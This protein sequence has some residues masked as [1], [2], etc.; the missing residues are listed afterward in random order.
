MGNTANYIV[1]YLSTMMSEI[2]W[3]PF[4]KALDILNFD[5][6]KIILIIG[7]SN[8]T[9]FHC[10][11]LL[12]FILAVTKSIVGNFEEFLVTVRKTN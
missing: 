11:R 2:A 5:F 12:L 1:T 7:F 4:F 8:H 3:I 10:Y 6:S 9:P